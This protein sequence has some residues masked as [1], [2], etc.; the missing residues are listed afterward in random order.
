MS[1]KAKNTALGYIYPIHAIINFRLGLL[2]SAINL[3]SYIIVMDYIGMEKL[4][5][6][7]LGHT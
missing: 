4:L 1:F 6:L 2:L 5:E 3:S 7:G